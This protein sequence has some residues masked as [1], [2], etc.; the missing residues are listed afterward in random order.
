MSNTNSLWDDWRYNR[1]S[2]YSSPHSTT[3]D[4]WVYV[5]IPTVKNYRLISYGHWEWTPKG[6]KR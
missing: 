1:T 2:F 6:G 5:P 4:E 3:T